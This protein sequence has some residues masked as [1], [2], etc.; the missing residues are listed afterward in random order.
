MEETGHLTEEGLARLIRGDLPTSETIELFRHLLRQCETCCARLAP[1]FHRS[2][3]TAE[4]SV[5]EPLAIDPYEL[6]F[7]RAVAAVRK[8][9]AALAHAREQARAEL[10]RI[11]S[12][13]AS[14]GA[15]GPPGSRPASSQS[16]W[17]WC[18]LVIEAAGELRRIDLQF[19][20]DLAEVGARLTDELRPGPYPAEAVADLQARA[21][22]EL[23]NLLRIGEDLDGA[24][25]ALH[26]S[27]SRLRR[28]TSDPMLGA[29]YLDLS[30]SL[31]RD[32]GQLAEALACLDAAE[33]LYAAHEASHLA[34]RSLVNA[35]SVHLVAGEPEAALSALCRAL[36]LLD[37]R[38]E[39]SLVIGTAHNILL[40]WVD[41]GQP[42]RAARILWQARG[43]YE[44]PGSDLGRQRLLG[45][46]AR[47][48]RGLGQS[49]RAARLLR[50]EK[51]GFEAADRA[52]DAALVG[53]DL[54]SVLVELGESGE[55][56]NLVEEMLRTFR[57]LRI[58]RPALAA[59][60]LLRDAVLQGTATA[61]MVR[62]VAG[63]IR[64]I[65]EGPPEPGPDLDLP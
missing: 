32:R 18:E 48:A 15:A 19:A 3:D 13:P 42:E 52:F 21:W 47:I 7:A 55:V 1:L 30:A 31:L 37:R 20:L 4:S 39:P 43:L 33:R 28:G 49:A 62:E 59:I 58:A 8:E 44:I 34:G 24:Q 38:R 14:G 16:Y 57:R 60:L 65:V 45:I 26:R 10:E 51:A 36:R 22:M 54:A 29:R 6:P 17:A 41:T 63:Q 2:W 23:G 9:A 5:P 50:E 53:L 46:E 56:L 64:R 35:A 61:A 25:S 12:G 11:F 27:L 40:A